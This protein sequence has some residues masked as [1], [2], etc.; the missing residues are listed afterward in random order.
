MSVAAAFSVSS[1][2]MPTTHYNFA[3]EA[4]SLVPPQSTNVVPHYLSV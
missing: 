3:I 1:R 2:P 4:V